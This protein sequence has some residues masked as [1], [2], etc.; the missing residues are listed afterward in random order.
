MK[1]IK[2]ISTLSDLIYAKKGLRLINILS[3]LSNFLKIKKK[4]L[5]YI[6]MNEEVMSK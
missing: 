1:I 3:Y 4:C 6:F 2:R 5:V